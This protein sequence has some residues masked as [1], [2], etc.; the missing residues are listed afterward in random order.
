MKPTFTFAALLLSASVLHAD[1]IKV[2]AGA[3]AVD[4]VFDLKGSNDACKAMVE[5]YM[6]NSQDAKPAGK[7]INPVDASM[8]RFYDN[9][10]MLR[11]TSDSTHFHLDTQSDMKKLAGAAK[12]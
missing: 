2:G 7:A 6:K 1:P 4:W 11:V 3:R 8:V 10:D 12:D 5:E 9:G